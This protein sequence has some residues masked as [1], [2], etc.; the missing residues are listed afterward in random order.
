MANKDAWK[1]IQQAHASGQLSRLHQEL[2]FKKPR[3]IAELY[4]PKNDPFELQ[5]LA[6]NASTR[7]TE[8]KLREALEAWM[9]RES[10][11]LPLP[12]HALQFAKKR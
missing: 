7:E 6:G 10:D 2:Y 12:S 4:D 3:L 8:D 9:I 1:A 11:F 5:N